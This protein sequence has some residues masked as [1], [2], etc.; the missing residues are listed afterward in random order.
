MSIFMFLI[1]LFYPFTLLEILGGFKE[2]DLATDYYV[3]CVLIL[4]LFIYS[5]LKVIPRANLLTASEKL[6]KAHFEAAN[7]GSTQAPDPLAPVDGHF[8]CFVKGGDGHLWVF[9]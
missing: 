8:I 9:L 3:G 7:L 1:S 6:E 4:C 5:P 2:K